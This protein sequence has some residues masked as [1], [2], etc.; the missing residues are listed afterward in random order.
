MTPSTLSFGQEAR[1][2]KRSLLD[3]NKECSLIGLLVDLYGFKED[4]L[5]KKTMSVTVQGVHHHLISY[6]KIKDVIIKALW[7]PS[8]DLML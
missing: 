2:L 3:H 7:T 1:G 5:V 6:Y 4:G 8:E